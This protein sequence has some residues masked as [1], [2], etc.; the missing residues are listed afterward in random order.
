MF[1]MLA[2]R[3]F[4][5]MTTLA[6]N[7]ATHLAALPPVRAPLFISWDVAT[8]CN[9]RCGMCD[10]WREPGQGL[11][12]A[13]RAKIVEDMGRS[14]VWMLSLCGGEPFADPDIAAL[15]A[16]AKQQGMLVSVSTNGSLLRPHMSTVGNLNAVVVSVD[17]HIP[18]EHDRRRGMPGLF[19]EIVDGISALKKLPRRPAIR[20]RC[21]LDRRNIHALD[22]YL[23]FWKTRVDEVLL[24]PLHHVPGIGFK[25]PPEALSGAMPAAAWFFRTLKRHGIDNRYNREI[26]EFL[27][28]G[29]RYTRRTPCHCGTYYLEIDAQGILWNCGN[30]HYRIGDLKSERMLDLTRRHAAAVRRF[31]RD[32][33]C[34]CWYNCA[35][36]DV[37]I[38]AATGSGLLRRRPL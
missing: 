4:R 29:D 21:L 26:W 34:S 20:V 17:S 15:V 27:D 3:P 23:S 38:S 11:S 5:W 28:T 24:Q 12:A 13:Q 7:T 8:S 16:A 14:G 9:C 6:A 37:Y 19:Q 31:H 18:E 25:N 35:M 32:R 36:L 22:E 30:H 10:R 2:C 33:S 1:E